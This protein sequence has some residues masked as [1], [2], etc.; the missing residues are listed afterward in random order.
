MPRSSDERA[1]ASA[2]AELT[3]AQLVVVLDARQL[4]AAGS[5]DDFFDL[6]DTLLDDAAVTRTLAALTRAELHDLHA[7]GTS[8]LPTTASPRLREL[9]L[10]DADGAPL[11]SVAAKAAEATDAAPFSLTDAPPPSGAL[12]T[13]TA[14]EQAMTSAAALADLVVWSSSNPLARTATGAVTATERKRLIE[15]GA[16]T[17]AAELDDLVALG[18]TAGLLTAVDREWLAT[19]DGA[20]WLEL[21]TVDR[22]RRVAEAF[23]RALPRGIRSPDGGYA[24][25]TVWPGAYPRDTAWPAAAASLVSQATRWG[26]IAA[27]GSEPAW[28]APLRA[29]APADVAAL[30]QHLAPEIDRVYVQADLSV[31][32]PGTLVPSVELRLRAMAHRETRAQASTYRFSAETLR[33]AVAAGET[34]DSLRAFIAGISLTGIPQPL[35]YLIDEAA[36]RRTV[37]RVGIDPV[38][39]HTVVSADDPQLLATIAVDQAVRP[40]GLVRDGDRLVSRVSRDA[41]FWTLVD[42]RYSAAAI[43]A[44]GDVERLRR[45][46]ASP[47]PVAAVPPTERYA[48]LI[49]RLRAA[50]SENADA[51]WLERELEQAVKTRATIEVA[52]ELPGGDLRSFTIEATGL[53]GGRLRGRDRAVDV[54]R[55]LPVSSIRSA[56]P[57]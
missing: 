26:L 1:L 6:A 23:A 3:D 9:A 18:A 17:D 21:G 48:P 44:G 28:A 22:W 7:A 32:A 4:P 12:A 16:I 51:A 20:E 30:A 2:L 24:A 39:G 55:T 36:D 27:D 49:A 45:R 37:A 8:P 33:A 38:S 47:A 29:G 25:S 57:V 53:G 15:A 5:W 42:A 40:V 13:G 52:V 14:A 11:S 56:R 31:I 19:P 43:D 10:L 34:A 35:D 41:V 54:E 50:H 46:T